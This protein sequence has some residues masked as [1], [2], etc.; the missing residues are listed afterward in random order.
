MTVTVG[1]TFYIT[2][3]AYG[4]RPP[5]VLEWRL[6]DDVVTVLQN[7]SDV[8]REDSFISH[9][10][11]NITPSRNYQ[12][13][14]L[15]CVATHSEL[16]TNRQLSVYLNVQ[17]KQFISNTTPIHLLQPDSVNFFT[18]EVLMSVK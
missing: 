3:A 10:V 14:S 8:V 1:E 16:Q 9:K 11:L 13:K 4:A 15:C 7:Q 2:C 6:P 12:G 18:T 5:A 17:G